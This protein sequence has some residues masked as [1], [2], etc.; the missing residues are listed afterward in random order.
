MPL[1]VEAV[2]KNGVLKLLTPLDLVEDQHVILQVVTLD[3]S[4][5]EAKVNLKD[6]SFAGIWPAELG[7]DVQETIA[8]IRA[9]TNTKLAQ[10]ADAPMPPPETITMRG[11]WSHVDPN[12]LTQALAEVRAATNR[13]LQQVMDEV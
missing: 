12:E 13:R 7:L 6:T 2:Y 9:Q 10:L 8:A 11:L 4:E 5:S 3:V 1:A